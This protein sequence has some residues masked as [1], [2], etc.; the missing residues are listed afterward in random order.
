MASVLQLGK[1][2]VSNLFIFGRKS[3][4]HD[5]GKDH[6]ILATRFSIVRGLSVA[7]DWGRV[8]AP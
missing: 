7:G 8:K 5:F 6:I 2:S 1:L 4:N 3:Q